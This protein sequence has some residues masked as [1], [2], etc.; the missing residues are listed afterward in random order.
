MGETAK[1]VVTIEDQEKIIK[2]TRRKE[3]Q[4]KIDKWN[5][6]LDKVN[7]QIEELTDEQTRL[8]ECLEEWDT[9]KTTYSG[10]D[11]LSEVVITN[12]FEGVC[13]DKIKDDL[14]ASVAQM[15]LT[16]SKVSGLNDNV[17]LQISKLNEYKTLINGELVT[18]RSE[19]NSI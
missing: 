1:T 13:A 15:D 6:K 16:Y 4:S 11:I 7:L 12:V 5:Y 19:L 8:N 17:G 14:T 10:N 18:L 9:Q 2:E 3:I